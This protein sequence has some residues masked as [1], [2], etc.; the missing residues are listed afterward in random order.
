MDIKYKYSNLA[1]F[2]SKDDNFL[3]RKYPYI[4]SKYRGEF[5]R[6]RDRVIHCN[7][8][9]RLKFK[10]QVF[11]Y[12]EGDHFRTR[13][14]HSL[15]VSQIARSVARV[16]KLNE[17]LCEV[18]SLAHDLGHTPFGHAGEIALSNCL[19][20][21]IFDHNMQSLRILILLENNYKNQRGLN[22]S[23]NCID[24]LIKH[25]GPL[26]NYDIVHNQLPEILDYGINLK[27][28]GSLEAQISSL[29]DDIAYN[30]HDIDDG[31]RAD[32]FNI[33]DLLE[34]KYLNKVFKKNKKI[35][36]NEIVRKLLNILVTD[37]I[38]NSQKK[39]K[40]EEIKKIDDVYKRNFNLI[41]F[42]DDVSIGLEEIR[43]FLNIKMYNHESIRKWNINSENI[44]KQIFSYFK[45]NIKKIPNLNKDFSEDRNIADYIS[46]MTDKFALNLYNSIK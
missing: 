42:S 32:L 10:T 5:Q 46:G 12:Y 37:L 43:N 16:L 15:E 1:S 33:D 24:G 13:L 23:L 28:S 22:L 34:L 6:D 17:D 11:V 41:N 25:N 45:K 36:K 35:T 3:G 21:D 40:K 18:L 38:E 31:L 27:N 4:P 8:F 14:T 29:S 2:A 44:I 9:R 26:T 39:I 30:C 7:S 20:N 19:N